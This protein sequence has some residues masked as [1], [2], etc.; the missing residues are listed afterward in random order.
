MHAVVHAFMHARCVCVCLCMDACTRAS[1]HECIYV[2]MRVCIMYVRVSVCVYARHAW[3]HCIDALLGERH[4]P[5]HV[6]L[7]T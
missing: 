4:A 2:R 1:M 7:C 3:M 5:L 6:A